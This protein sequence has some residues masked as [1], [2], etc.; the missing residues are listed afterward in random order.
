[1]FRARHS[2]ANRAGARHGTGALIAIALHAAVLGTLLSVEPARTGLRA[3]APIMVDLLAPPAPR[4]RPD[5]TVEPPKPGPVAKAR[6]K[7]VAPQPI[8]A[9]AASAPGPVVA[10]PQPPSPPMP[11]PADATPMPA[12][13]PAPALPLTQPIFNAGYLENPAPV[14]PSLSRRSGERGRVTLRVLVNPEGRSAEVEVRTSSGF[15]RLDAAARATVLRWK[16]VPARRGEEAVPA[17]V[18]IPI[19]FKLEG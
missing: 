1:M 8:L 15:A 16:F 13:V 11:V 18:L 4:A 19:T 2:T 7:A 6:P 12:A 14:Y 17:W 3:A 10:A 5:K 9:V